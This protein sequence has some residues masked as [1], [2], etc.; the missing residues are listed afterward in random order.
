VRRTPVGVGLLPELFRRVP[1]V[2]R[3]LDPDYPVCALGS[4]ASTI[5][6]GQPGE[7]AFGE[8]SPYRRMLDLGVSLIGLGVSLNTNSFI[9][10]FDAELASDYRFPVYEDEAGVATTITASGDR[11]AVRRRV[12]RPI[13]QQRVQPSTI[14]GAIDDPLALTSFVENGVQCFRWDVRRLHAWAIR[15]ARTRLAAG[16]PPCWLE[17]LSESD[18]AG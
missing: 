17:R 4:N 5:V 3:S 1:G 2:S 18:A 15:H 10:T 11:I 7:D 9:H 6:G 12:L 13:L 16:R 8:E 14:A